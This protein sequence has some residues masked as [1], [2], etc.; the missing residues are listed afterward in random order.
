M[1]SRIYKKKKIEAE[2]EVTVIPQIEQLRLLRLSIAQRFLSSPEQTLKLLREHRIL[3]DDEVVDAEDLKVASAEHLRRLNGRLSPA[4]RKVYS[5]EI[6]LLEWIAKH[7]EA[8]AA[9]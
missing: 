8:A 7:D 1:R 6:S 2:V 5:D 3:R 9:E 4:D